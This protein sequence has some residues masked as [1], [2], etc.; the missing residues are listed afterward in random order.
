[1]TLAMKILLPLAFVLFCTGCDS[2]QVPQKPQPAPAA[3]PA[4]AR[5]VIYASAGETFLVDG[6]DGKAWRYD[7]NAKA[8]LE[9]P[10]TSKIISYDSQGNRVP[11]DPKDPLGILDKPKPK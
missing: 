5:F 7:A 4:H 3:P 10:V 1:M 6:D 9:V 2:V 11:P 8:F